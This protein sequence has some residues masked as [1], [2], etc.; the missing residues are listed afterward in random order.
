MLHIED[1][2][3]EHFAR[4]M[5]HCQQR[6]ILMAFI[7]PCVSGHCVCACSLFVFIGQPIDRNSVL[8]GL[9]YYGSK[10]FVEDQRPGVSVHAVADR[11]LG[12]LQIVLCVFVLN[13]SH[14]A[15]VLCL[16]NRS[17][18]CYILHALSRNLFRRQ[19]ANAV[20]IRKVQYLHRILMS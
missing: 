18:F 3:V 5:L 12:Y 4:I 19:V 20:H 9:S 13:K 16:N 15:V 17:D 11:T 1:F 2:R 8:R 10:L 6:D 14:L 7:V